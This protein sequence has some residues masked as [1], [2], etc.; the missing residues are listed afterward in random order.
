MLFFLQPQLFITVVPSIGSSIR[1]KTN[2]TFNDDDALAEALR[3]SQ[4]PQVAAAPAALQALQQEGMSEEEQLQVA[5]ALSM[6][7]VV[8]AVA[9][10]PTAAANPSELESIPQ[11]IVVNLIKY[12]FSQKNYIRSNAEK[13][14]YDLQ[15][16]NEDSYI[17]FMGVPAFEGT[18]YEM[19]AKKVKEYCEEKA[20][21]FAQAQVLLK[22]AL[23]PF[24][25]PMTEFDKTYAN[26]YTI[27]QSQTFQTEVLAAFKR[28][29]DYTVTPIPERIEE[30]N[31]LISQALKKV[32]IL[33]V[34]ETLKANTEML[35][36]SV[37]AHKTISVEEF[38]KNSGITLKSSG[39]PPQKSDEA[40]ASPTIN[41]KPTTPNLMPQKAPLPQAVETLQN[42]LN[43]EFEQ[44]QR[45]NSN[46][47][48]MVYGRIIAP[49]Y[50]DKLQENI[51]DMFQRMNIKAANNFTKIEEI[52]GFHDQVEK[53]LEHKPQQRAYIEQSLKT[54]SIEHNNLVGK[55]YVTPV[56]SPRPQTQFD[57]MLTV[58]SQYHRV[59]QA[60]K[61]KPGVKNDIETLLQFFFAPLIEQA[62][63]CQVGMIGRM[64]M[65][66]KNLYDT[67]IDLYKK[68]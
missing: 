8:S 39:L 61:D 15:F 28:G 46:E 65:A 11:P 3:L 32:N 53:I 25:I 63:R 51:N 19:A 62:G 40:Q 33:P 9:L 20:I 54:S 42:E 13:L 30:N 23:E 68:I 5:M 24:T 34:F 22:R 45:A 38:L 43:K 29:S 58:A 67:L 37:C 14:I 44:R 48:V 59:Y 4:L 49:Q 1:D 7:D 50:Y 26:L 2:G 12:I 16:L 66:Q 36:S 31:T 55:V 18:L 10:K 47:T 60:L 41:T 21:N 6:N 64:F 57:Y 52:F 27:F 35:N 56:N 17:C